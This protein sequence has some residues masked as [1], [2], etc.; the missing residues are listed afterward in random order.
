MALTRT[1]SREISLDPAGLPSEL[2]SMVQMAF[3]RAAE[4]LQL[5]NTCALS[6]VGH[7]G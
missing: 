2:R 3:A 6:A 5:C 4:F 1:S 7:Q